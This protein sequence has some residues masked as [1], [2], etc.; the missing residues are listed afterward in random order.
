M[1]L[2]ARGFIAPEESH[3]A[4]GKMTHSGH[5]HVR[6]VLILSILNG[7]EWET[8]RMTEKY[9]RRRRQMNLLPQ[10]Y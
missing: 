10:Y 4:D 7:S 2:A 5:I 9:N 1:S 8:K 3:H 6:L